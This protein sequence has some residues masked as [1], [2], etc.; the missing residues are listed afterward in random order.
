[1]KQQARQQEHRDRLVLSRDLKQVRDISRAQD[2]SRTM[3]RQEKDRTMLLMATTERSDGL[4]S[5]KAINM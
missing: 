5:I 1:M 3:V 4:N 2:L